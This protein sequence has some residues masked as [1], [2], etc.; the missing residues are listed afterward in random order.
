MHR[1]V[2]KTVL[3]FI[4]CFS[5]VSQAIASNVMS[6]KMM[7]MSVAAQAL[8][9]HADMP[10]CDMS[11]EESDSSSSCCNCSSLCCISFFVFMSTPLEN[12]AFSSSSLKLSF[13]LN[14]V[15]NPSLNSLYKP[16]I[17]S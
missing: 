8:D 16:P 5:F 1:R 14:R 3:V 15:Q 13:T 9:V 7:S 10:N 6:Y 11:K 12:S 2:S 17:I 4:I